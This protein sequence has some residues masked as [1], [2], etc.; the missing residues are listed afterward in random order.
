MRQGMDGVDSLGVFVIRRRVAI[1]IVVG[2]I[3]AVLACFAARVR[4]NQEPEE[5]IFKDDPQYPL[6]KEFFELFGYDE[7]VVAA[8]SAE[9]VLEK[10]QVEMLG[11]I[12]ARL[13]EIPGVA[14]V[15]SLTLAEDV[16]ARDGGLQLVPL[17]D[18][19]PEDPA[20][21]MALWERIQANPVYRDLLVSPDARTALFDITLESG[22]DSR[23]REEILSRIREAFSEHT[24]RFYLSGSPVARAE[25]YRCIT[26]DF[27]TLMP[28]GVLLLVASMVLVFR[29]FLCVLLPML[30]IGLSTLWTIGFIYL[31]GS[32][33]NLFSVIIP[34]IIFIIGTSDCIHILSQYQDCR[35]SCST[36]R[37]ALHKTL[38]LM[39]QPC[40]LTSVT[41]MVCLASLYFGNLQPIR[42]FGVFA[43]VGIGF[44]FLLSIT[45]LPI[46]LSLGDTHA[47]TRERP[48]SDFLLG[49][50]AR[51]DR[52][53][54]QRRRTVLLASFILLV[55][56][57]VGM[58]F[59]HVETDAIKFGTRNM[60][61][62]SDTLYI[63]AQ[64]GGVIPLYVVVDSN[65]E[66][67]FKDPDL[68]SR[69]HALAEFLRG[70]DGVDKVVALS[71]LLRYVHYRVQGSD[72]AYYT[73]PPE[74]RQ[75]S[76]L[77]LMASLSGDEDL[78]SR[79][80]D[81]TYRKTSLGVRFR[82]HDFY[83]I[84]AW[85]RAVRAYLDEAFPGDGPVRAYTT[86][87]ALLCAN[88]MTPIL[89]GLEQSLF[90][91]A[92]ALF[93][94]MALL[95]R[96]WRV[97]LLSMVP[98]FVPLVMTL[99]TMGLLGISLNVGTAPLAA[100]A[101]GV[102]IDDTIHFLVRFRKEIGKDGDH[103]AAVW[104]TLRSVGKPILITSVVL[105]A[106]FVIFLFSN[107]Q[108]T[109][110]MGMLISFTVLSA[111]FADLILLPALILVF[112]PM[113]KLAGQA[114]GRGG[115]AAAG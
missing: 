45:L 33:L 22:L 43:A 39:L 97:A 70:L 35:H 78:L 30:A 25:M 77:F 98:N 93:L 24:E 6:L 114:G 19:P 44:A 91:A 72:P 71:D 5:L 9:N 65:Q 87:T 51:V 99:G 49:F 69:V 82:Y 101:L 100:I 68:L 52:L 41:T 66:G 83:R 96:S 46:G 40:L 79:F 112:K 63:E 13:L 20:Q 27:S 28:L 111:V 80:V 8:C 15:L 108:Y 59:L 14:R 89:I 12:G 48:R 56:G 76:E 61:T 74:A 11:S 10:R 67:G 106:G 23:E 73:I 95:F 86:G 38:S 55:M 17:V 31:V 81:D 2:V 29:N 60:T 32:E 16:V 1:L 94:I 88:I 58:W 90:V 103:E 37:Q 54:R 7:I 50:L 62:V 102:G 113:K 105:S 26:R 110:S 64:L 107:F 3:T 42:H 92:A 84:E 115:E 4:I 36:K 21:E 34:T 85:N 53:D 75:V 109:R 18:A 104:R 47:L 57:M